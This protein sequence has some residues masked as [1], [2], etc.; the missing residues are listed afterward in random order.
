MTSTDCKGFV[1]R[2]LQVLGDSKIGLGALG[3]QI[4]G[5]A[6]IDGDGFGPRCV[7]DLVLADKLGCAIAGILDDAHTACGQW[8]IDVQSQG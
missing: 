1:Q 5:V 3:A 6:Q 7:A 4:V 2:T 8:A